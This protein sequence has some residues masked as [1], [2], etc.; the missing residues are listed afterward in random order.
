MNSTSTNIFRDVRTILQE[1]RLA[2]VANDVEAIEQTAAAL[3]LLVAELHQELTGGLLAGVKDIR[4]V[5]ADARQTLGMVDKA[6]RT[7]HALLNAYRSLSDPM[8]V[9]SVEHY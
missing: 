4:S 2:I 9:P 8:A 1:L 3:H 5:N 6:K 7:A